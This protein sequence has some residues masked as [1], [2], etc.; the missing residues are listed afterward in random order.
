MARP[1]KLTPEQL[2]RTCNPQEFSFNTTADLDGP[3]TATG[4]ERAFEAISFS[5][6]I[7]DLVMGQSLLLLQS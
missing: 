6:G 4:Q 3:V 5:M 2:Y 7:L 1:S